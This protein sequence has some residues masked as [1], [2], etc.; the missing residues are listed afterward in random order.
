MAPVKKRQNPQLFAV[1]EESVK[2]DKQP[3][4]RAE[5]KNNAKQKQRA[6]CKALVERGQSRDPVAHH[7]VSVHQPHDHSRDNGGDHVLPAAICIGDAFFLSAHIFTI[8]FSKAY[9]QDMT[10]Y[11]LVRKR[12]L[13]GTSEKHPH[14]YGPLPLFAVQAILHIVPN[15]KGVFIR[16]SE[17]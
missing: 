11:H 12:D 13:R 8:F 7:G 4:Q 5:K 17:E 9:N 10:I 3:R 6:G 2:N 1:L 15:K 16:L 14:I